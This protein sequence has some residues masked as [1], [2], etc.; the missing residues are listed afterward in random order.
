MP[1]DKRIANVLAPEDAKNQC[2]LDPKC[3]R[4]N[5]HPPPCKTFGVA[6]VEKLEL[7]AKRFF[8]RVKGAS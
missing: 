3:H 6:M 7:A 2:G 4:I 8:E 5:G 1:L